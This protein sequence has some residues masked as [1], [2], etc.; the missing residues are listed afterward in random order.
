MSSIAYENGF[1]WKTLWNLS[2]NASL[3]ALRKNPNVLMTGDIVHIPDLT[4]RNEPGATEQTHKF[5]LKGVPEFL[6]MKIMDAQHNPRPNLQY[7]ITIEGNS[8]HGTT[9]GTGQL[10][11]SIPPNARTGKLTFAAPLAGTTN[12]V[13]AKIAAI[14]GKTHGPRPK[15][16]VMI[17]QLGS[18]NPISAV[19][20]IKARLA[21][22]GFYQGPV[23][24]NLD[25]S[26]AKAITR[27]QRKKKLP[28]TGLADDATKALIQKIHGH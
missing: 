6:R 20:G 24:E 17:L 1:F 8:R 15:Q 12:P 23:D 28:M 10:K 19:S 2:Q 25:D 27:F 7:I 21:N 16:Q 18:L 9:D 4:V 13:A 22:L 3:K 11:E 26:T 5:V 14:T